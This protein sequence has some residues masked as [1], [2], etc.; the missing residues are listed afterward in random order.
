MVTVHLLH[1][2]PNV[3]FLFI[4]SLGM[5]CEQRNAMDPDHPETWRELCERLKIRIVTTSPPQ[6]KRE[7]SDEDGIGTFVRNRVAIYC[8][9]QNV[10]NV[11]CFLDE[12][13]AW[14]LV[15][16]VNDT[17]P[18]FEQNPTV[19]IHVD[20]TSTL[21]FSADDAM[22]CKIEVVK[23]VPSKDVDVFQAYPPMWPPRVIIA[24]VESETDSTISV[25]FSGNTRKFATGFDEA[26]IGKKRVKQDEDEYAEWF[27]VCRGIDIT[28]EARR[29]WLLEIFGPKVLKSSPC[30]VR[31]KKLPKNDTGFEAFLQELYAEINVRKAG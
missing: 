13:I 23:D 28:V 3:F 17:D 25:V 2:Y 26:E 22:E 21:T 19:K 12:F 5:Y 18:E 31:V 7:V 9:K 27:R 10:K 16:R 4:K 29:S 14:R 1:E 11:Y 15:T 6:G 24:T 30:V 8:D 20:T